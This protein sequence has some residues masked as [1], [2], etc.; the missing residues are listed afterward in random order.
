[1]SKPRAISSLIQQGGATDRLLERVQYH[2]GLERLLHE[3]LPPE[4]ARHM[5][6]ANL[7]Y[8]TLILQVDSAAWAA[9][10]RYLV[11]DLLKRLQ[12]LPAL[13]SLAEIRLRIAPASE[14]PRPVRHKREM[15]VTASDVLLD[16]AKAASDPELRDALA[17]LA[18]H[19]HTE[20]D[21]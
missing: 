17:R 21:D 19:A 3:N 4:L 7:R 8:D 10:L 13:A 18:R 2:A 12:Q 5:R 11:P 1:M 6:V 9:R 14:Q 16:A 15:S 20:R